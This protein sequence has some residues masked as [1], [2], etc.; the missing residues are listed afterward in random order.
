[1]LLPQSLGCP[2]LEGRMVVGVV[3]YHYK[4]RRGEPHER[5]F[6][7]SGGNFGVA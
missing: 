7:Y 2:V 5:N 3:V 4:V 6:V 1:M